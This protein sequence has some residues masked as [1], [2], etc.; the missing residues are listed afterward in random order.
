MTSFIVGDGRRL[1]VSCQCS[2]NYCLQ[3][4]MVARFGFSK[5]DNHTVRFTVDLCHELNLLSA[6][7]RIFL[8]DAY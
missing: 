4:V 7:F 6:F 3:C 5:P 8:V 1:V 2:I